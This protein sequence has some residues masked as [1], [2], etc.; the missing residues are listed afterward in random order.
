MIE[1]RK[2]VVC[3]LYKPQP[4]TQGLVYGPETLP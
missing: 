4:K 3:T 2:G 1:G